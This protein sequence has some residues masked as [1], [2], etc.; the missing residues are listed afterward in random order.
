MLGHKVLHVHLYDKTEAQ[1]YN[2]C[3]CHCY[4]FQSLCNITQRDTVSKILMSINEN[5]FL[6]DIQAV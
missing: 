5:V 1:L 6:Q 4:L 3:H 2:H